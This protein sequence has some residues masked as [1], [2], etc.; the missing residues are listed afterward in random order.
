MKL[1]DLSDKKNDDTSYRYDLHR[2]SPHHYLN[3]L[4]TYKLMPEASDAKHENKYLTKPGDKFVKYR[5]LS[6]SIRRGFS[7]NNRYVETEQEIQYYSSKYQ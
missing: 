1:P 4:K 6:R 2:I 7:T 5:R 3:T